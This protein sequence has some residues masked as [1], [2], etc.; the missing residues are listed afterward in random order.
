MCSRS[1]FFAIHGRGANIKSIIE[2]KERMD[3]RETLEVESTGFRNGVELRAERG[4]SGITLE[5]LVLV[6]L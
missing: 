2:G 6:T 4:D 5:F 1:S 3:L